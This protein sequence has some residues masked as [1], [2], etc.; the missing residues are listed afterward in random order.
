MRGNKFHGQNGMCPKLLSLQ[1]WLGEQID[2]RRG[3]L[4]ERRGTEVEK[5]GG[6]STKRVINCLRE[7]GLCVSVKRVTKKSIEEQVDASPP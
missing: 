7:V 1:T 3:S 5:K 2:P 6:G 4:K